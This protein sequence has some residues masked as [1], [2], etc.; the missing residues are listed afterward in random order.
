MKAIVRPLGRIWEVFVASLLEELGCD[1]ST[2]CSYELHLA[3]DAWLKWRSWWVQRSPE[4]DEN[5]S[6]DDYSRE[7]RWHV[8]PGNNALDHVS[9]RVKVGERPI[10]GGSLPPTSR[11]S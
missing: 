6:S 2:P 9:L 8:G 10:R 5:S 4:G 3:N 11:E 7:K 1:I